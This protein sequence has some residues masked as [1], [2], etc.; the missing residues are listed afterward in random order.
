MVYLLYNTRNYTTF[1][2]ETHDTAFQTFIHPKNKLKVRQNP[3]PFQ[4][5][6]PKIR[7]PSE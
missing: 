4:A 3:H 5:T 2:I 7:P 1:G 6:T